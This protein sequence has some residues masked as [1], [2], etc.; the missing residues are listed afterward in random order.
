[1]RD[2]DYIRQL[3]IFRTFGTLKVYLTLAWLPECLQSLGLCASE[4]LRM[5]MSMKTGEFTVMATKF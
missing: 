5:G 4:N 1:M 2:G 3:E